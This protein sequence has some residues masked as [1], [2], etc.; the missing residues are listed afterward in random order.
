MS[1]WLMIL[2]LLVLF[3]LSVKTVLLEKKMCIYLK[4]GCTCLKL[5]STKLLTSLEGPRF[6]FLFDGKKI[7]MAYIELCVGEKMNLKNP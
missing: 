4:Y 2:N 6:M 3:T 1:P 7:I 5:F